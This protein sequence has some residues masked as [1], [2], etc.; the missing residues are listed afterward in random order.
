[1]ASSNRKISVIM[2]ADA[3]GYSKHMEANEDATLASYKECEAILKD[4][5]KKHNGSI[6][7]TGGDSVLTEF[8]SA[9]NAVECGVEF[10]RAIKEKNS[11][12][13][14]QVNIEF[15][16]G[17]NMGDVVETDGNLLGDGVNIAARLEALSMPGGV[18]ISKSVHDMIVGKTELTF[19]NQGLQKVKQNEFYVYDV[20]IDPTQ[21]RTLKTK[22]NSTRNNPLILSAIGAGVLA[23]GIV[24]FQNLFQSDNVGDDFQRIALL[25]LDPGSDDQTIINLASGLTEDLSTSL[26]SASKKLTVVT[27]NEAPTDSENLYSE[28]NARYLID[29]SIRQSGS[30][31]RIS[32]SLTDTKNQIKI[33]SEKFDKE[34]NAENFFNLQDEIVEN[35]IDALIGNGAVLAQEVAKNFSKTGTENLSAYECVNF[36]RGQYFKN[37]SPEMHSQGLSCLRNSVIDDPEYKEAWALLAHMV[38]WGYS[39]YVPFFQAIDKEGLSEA[40]NAID[41]AIRIDKNYARAYATKAELYFYER[42]YDSMMINAKKAFELAPGDAYNVGH[43]AYV[44]A[45]SGMGCDEPE[46][47]KIKYS[48]DKDACSRLEWGYE[49]SLLANKLDAVSS[50]T[51]ENYGLQAYYSSKNNWQAALDAMEEVPTPSFHWWNFHMGSSFHFLGDKDRARSYF[52]VVKEAYG[53]NAIEMLGEGVKMWN[54]EPLFHRFNHLIDE[55]SWK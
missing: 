18:S 45:L 4:L 52:N 32:I 15:R 3:V 43:I 20:V 28:I 2:I 25:S 27:L 1:M 7:N 40:F 38:A 22:G 21:T 35:V 44:T 33:W 8:S 31:V 55:Y 41:N 17:I 42:E 47:I 9:V 36:V 23:L 54:Y 37:L 49:K 11:K 34:F 13:D 48:I 6:F 50:L 10:Q 19:K 24:L 51:F 46:K 26:T 53:E 12:Q 16:V 39:L 29:G 14:N 5:L 30:N